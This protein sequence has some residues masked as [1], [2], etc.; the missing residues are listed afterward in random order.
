[1]LCNGGNVACEP[2]F[3]LLE[4]TCAPYTPDVVERVSGVDAHSLAQATELLSSSKRVAY[5]SWT[6]IG[7]HSNATQTERAVAI[8]YAL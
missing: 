5:H 4:R 6:G 8:L 2:V 7:Q 1:P 3:A